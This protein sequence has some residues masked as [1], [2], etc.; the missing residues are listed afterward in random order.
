MER[1]F[2]AGGVVLRKMR[3]RWFLAVIEPHMK[4]PKRPAVPGRKRSTPHTP[5]IVALPK[6]AIDPGEK[7]ED[8]AL[9]EVHEETGLR[10]AQITKLVD[11]KYFYVR[12]W[13]GHERVFKIVSFFLLLYRSGRMGNIAP[14]MRV[15]VNHAFWMPL[16]EGPTRL[17]YKG[18][19][20]VAQRALQYVTDHPELGADAP[21]TPH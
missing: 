4:R 16:E 15:E 21:D 11:I 9:R 6:G 7:A 5:R 20:E 1:E 8:T 10:A 14:E 2:S 12:S 19:R 17:S 18:E 3:G 13:G